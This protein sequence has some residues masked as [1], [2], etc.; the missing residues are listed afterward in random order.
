MALVIGPRL[1]LASVERRLGI[2]NAIREKTARPAHAFTALDG[3]RVSR[4]RSRDENFQNARLVRK[5]SVVASGFVSA[6][7]KHGTRRIGK[8]R[9]AARTPRNGVDNGELNP[10]VIRLFFGSALSAGFRCVVRIRSRVLVRQ[11]AG[12]VSHVFA[13]LTRNLVLSEKF[14]NEILERTLR[15]RK[16]KLTA[17]TPVVSRAESPNVARWFLLAR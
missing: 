8:A 2:L 12:N 1:D 7:R 11:R 17:S 13:A 16:H 4:I 14:R 3:W 6:K 5:L 10:V 9:V 15:V